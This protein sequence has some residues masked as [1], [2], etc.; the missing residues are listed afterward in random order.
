MSYVQ[1]HSYKN[2]E[3]LLL[4]LPTCLAYHD[5]GAILGAVHIS[6]CLLRTSR[7][8]THTPGPVNIEIRTLRTEVLICRRIAVC[9]VLDMPLRLRSMASIASPFVPYHP[10]PRLRAPVALVLVDPSRNATDAMY[11][12]P[13][14]PYHAIHTSYIRYGALRHSLR[15]VP[16]SQPAS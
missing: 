3:H 16:A 9:C 11:Q 14:I 8:P 4:L 10:K 7:H 6:T 15:L 2:H 1:N 5:Q 13:S 12:H